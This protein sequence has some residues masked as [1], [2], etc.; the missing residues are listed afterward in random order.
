LDTQNQQRKVDCACPDPPCWAAGG[1]AL[2]RLLVPFGNDIYP[3]SEEPGYDPNK[4][5][6]ASD[7]PMPLYDPVLQAII[8]DFKKFTASAIESYNEPRFWYGSKSLEVVLMA[9]IN[10]RG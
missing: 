3:Q 5:I 10:K 7:I 1:R 2:V 8:R 4:K 6:I 9:H